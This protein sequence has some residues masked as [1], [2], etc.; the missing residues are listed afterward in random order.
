LVELIAEG[1]RSS[2]IG[3]K[4]QNWSLLRGL[5]WLCGSHDAETKECNLQT[6]LHNLEAWINASADVT[7][8]CGDLQEQ[9]KFPLLNRD[10]ISFGANTTK[11]HLIRL[12]SMLEKL[13]KILS[14]AGY[15]FT[16]QDIVAILSSMTEEVRHRLRY[17]ATYLLELLGNLFESL[18]ALIDRR[19]RK[20]PTNR[21][22]EMIMPAGVTSDVFRDLY[23]SV[24]AFKRYSPERIRDFTPTAMPLLRKPYR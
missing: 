13:H 3:D 6:T 21:V 23:G 22:D 15:S 10:L 8:W 14:A 24:L 4:Y 9:L 2:F 11:H 1:S 7:F 12:S 19:F 20:N 16:A 18:N 5:R 17:H